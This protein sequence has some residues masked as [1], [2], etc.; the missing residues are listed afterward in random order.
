MVYN[1][2]LSVSIDTSV[3]EEKSIPNQV[4]GYA[5]NFCTF[6]PRYRIQFFCYFRTT[7]AANNTKASRI[8]RYTSGIISYFI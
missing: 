5:Y 1:S 8:N 3:S 6:N 7:S 4:K 2:T